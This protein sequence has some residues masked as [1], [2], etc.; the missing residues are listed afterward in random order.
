MIKEKKHIIQKV[1]VD[2]EYNGD[3]KGLEL[4]NMVSR[5]CREMLLPYLENLLDQ[6]EASEIITRISKIEL[7]L[8][9]D[10]KEEWLSVL[11]KKTGIALKD[12]LDLVRYFSSQDLL[13]RNIEKTSGF[14]E[15]SDKPV[16]VH[17]SDEFFQALFY[18]L[19]NASLPWWWDNSVSL[20]QTFSDW[21]GSGLSEQI[22]TVIIEIIKEKEAAKRLAL[23]CRPGLFPAAL[24]R[25]H[26]PR[27]GF[28]RKLIPVLNKL[29]AYFPADKEAET[30]VFFETALLQYATLTNNEFVLK[31]LLAINKWF[32]HVCTEYELKTKAATAIK[33]KKE[34]F[35][36]MATTLDEIKDLMLSAFSSSLS[37]TELNLSGSR[38]SYDIIKNH[39]GKLPGLAGKEKDPVNEN[40]GESAKTIS[41]N[42]MD[43]A[44][45][46]IPGQAEHG[47]EPD[48][49]PIYII[50]AGVI[51]VAPLLP[52]LFKRLELLLEGKIENP[53]LAVM[54]L[55]FITYGN[56]EANEY[57]MPLYKILCGIPMK[58]AVNTRITLEEKQKEEANEL[59]RSVIEFWTVLKDTSPET[60]RSTFLQRN[61]K[62]MLVNNEWKLM[63]EQKPWDM[64]LKQLPWSI[65]M[66]KISWMDNLVRTEWS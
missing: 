28:I 50:N 65:Q 20:R 54:L 29:A 57:D 60:L 55:H 33:W 18:Y 15:G 40:V 7:E 51:L 39:P 1:V 44:T 61:G 13:F 48:N 25:I 32:A 14:E 45:K 19:K 21:L 58:Q 22:P 5:W 49:E 42:Q 43:L 9:T 63:V 52:T 8:D 34:L 31:F 27:Q 10:T 3:V 64:L 37:A 47:Q 36:R 41:V 6:D 11:M 2:L 35:T 56:E 16:R 24:S 26:P 53:S 12:K 59:L 4:E 62:L 17:S 66:I 30:L 38:G 46:A 23:L